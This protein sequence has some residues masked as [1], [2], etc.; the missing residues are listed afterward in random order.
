M[1]AK[2][3][4]HEAAAASDGYYQA[5]NYAHMVWAGLAPT[6]VTR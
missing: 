4:V 3:N 1:P 2:G 6:T 5:T